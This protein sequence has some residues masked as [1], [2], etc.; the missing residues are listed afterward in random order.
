MNR[1]II[2]DDIDEVGLGISGPQVKPELGQTSECGP[3]TLQVIDLTGDGIE[4]GQHPESGVAFMAAL[5]Q[6]LC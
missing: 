5:G 4:C 2:N 1:P 6:R 3:S